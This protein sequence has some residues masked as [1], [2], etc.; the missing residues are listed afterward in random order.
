MT[1]KAIQSVGIFLEIKRLPKNS[2]SCFQKVCV[3]EV[4]IICIILILQQKV[5]VQ[6]SSRGNGLSHLCGVFPQGHSSKGK[7]SF[8][9]EY[10][11]FQPGREAG[12]MELG[13]AGGEILV[14]CISMEYCVCAGAAARAAGCSR[15]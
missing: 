7:W 15:T 6:F 12:V 14:R 10:C 13:E 1:I 4:K 9:A 2:A 5:C 8:G 3:D 11:D